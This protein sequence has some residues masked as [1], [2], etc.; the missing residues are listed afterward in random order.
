MGLGVYGL[1][2]RLLGVLLS[3]HAF[4]DKNQLEMTVATCAKDA[5]MRDVED[6]GRK[7]RYMLSVS[8]HPEWVLSKLDL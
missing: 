6:D 7:L 2:R 3:I 8:T 1:V 5:P 4:E